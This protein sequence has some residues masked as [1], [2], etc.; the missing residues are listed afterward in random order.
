MTLQEFIIRIRLQGGQASRDLRKIMQAANATKD[1]LNAAGSAA[2][3]ADKKIGRIGKSAN[4]T[5]SSLMKMTRALR[6]GTSI[7]GKGSGSGI[8]ANVGSV[9][10]AL[11]V[12][13]PPLMALSAAAIAAASSLRTI[14]EFEREVAANV[15]AIDPRDEN[16]NVRTQAQINAIS[17]E[18][19]RLAANGLEKNVNGKNVLA[20]RTATQTIKD[21]GALERAG[22]RATEQTAAAYA[23]FSMMAEGASD[24]DKATAAAVASKEA[25]RRTGMKSGAEFAKA[26]DE[27]LSKNIKL[28]GDTQRNVQEVLRAQPKAQALIEEAGLTSSEAFAIQA[29]NASV[30]PTARAAAHHLNSMFVDKLAGADK[31]KVQALKESGTQL[32][33]DDGKFLGLANMNNELK[34]LEAKGGSAAAAILSVVGENNVGP[35]LNFFKHFGEFQRTTEGFDKD[36]TLA[37]D[38]AAFA[39]ANTPD[40]KLSEIGAAFERLALA[41]GSTGLG[42]LLNGLANVVILVAD[43]LTAAISGIAKLTSPVMEALAALG[44]WIL[45]WV[46]KLTDMLPEGLKQFFSIGGSQKIAD[47]KNGKAQTAAAPTKSVA[48]AE[49]QAVSTRRT[50][51]EVIG[52]ANQITSIAADAQ[53]KVALFD[54]LLRAAQAF[55]RS[56]PLWVQSAKFGV[57]AELFSMVA[58]IQQMGPR[59]QAAGYQ[60]GVSYNTGLQAGLASPVGFNPT[61]TGSVTNNYYNDNSNKAKV[62]VNGAD[63][64]RIMQEVNTVKT[65]VARGL[66][67]IRRG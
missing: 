45:G 36:A 61:Q 54:P 42:S 40:S 17:N 50:Q 25:T 53:A 37:A 10:G 46:Y 38:N 32:Y 7:G 55:A 51:Q 62:V 39:I 60:L 15:I 29:M 2:S 48:A 16:G 18:Q 26:F 11:R 49:A 34:E 3:N 66:E 47:E 64:R 41:L 63:H 65:Q 20:S 24:D 59:L 21:I 5:T 58:M 57:Q 19:R 33:G 6:V 22:I 35:M 8:T 12:L 52:V 30:E 31:K 14:A 27:E 28:A 23:R 67:G 4:S 9:L 56:M 44:D 1:S 13:P 43:V